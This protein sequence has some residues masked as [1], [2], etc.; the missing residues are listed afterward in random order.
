VRLAIFSSIASRIP[1][2]RV[3]DLYCGSGAYGLE[4]LSR[5][6]SGAVF[7]DEDGAALAACK[8]NAAAIGVSDVVRVHKSSVERY[9]AR[10]A[11]EAFDLVFCDPPYGSRVDLQ[12]VV[13][14]LAPEALV[15][16]E[17]RW[18]DEPPPDVDGMVVAADR[19]YGDTR[20]LTFS[21][22]RAR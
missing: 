7:V 22:S 18:R 11:A 6:A 4:A 20:V 19:R 12:R 2:A 21:T 5:G 17:S 1:D 8:A 9:L 15:I 10:G 3:L 14:L 16:V 13:P